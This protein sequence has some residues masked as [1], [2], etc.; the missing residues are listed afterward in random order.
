MLKK[1]IIPILQYTDQFSIKT[2]KFSTPRNIGNLLQYVKVFNKRQSDELSLINLTKK[3][4]NKSFDFKY[5]EEITAYCNMPLSVGGSISQIQEIEKLLLAGTDKVILGKSILDDQNF[6]K[7]IIKNFGSQIIIA[8]V[9]INYIDKDYF[10]NC[11]DNIN[12]LD[13]IKFL[14][15][16]GVGEILIN[17]VHKEGQM[18]GYDLILIDKIYKNL[19]RPIL[20]NGGAS[21]SDDFKNVLKIDKIQGAC[22]SSIFLFTEETPNS[23]KKQM[24]KNILLRN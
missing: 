11:N 12:Y 22:A 19:Q 6:L 9:D 17:C 4:L 3:F 5:L 20:I 15:D 1:R 13:Y 24:P 16:E 2:K 18:N 14:Q 23:I 21:C 10:L 7:D 8:S